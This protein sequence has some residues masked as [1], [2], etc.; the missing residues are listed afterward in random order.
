M[1]STPSKYSRFGALLA[2]T[3]L[4][5]TVT[6]A[7]AEN[8]KFTQTWNES[9]M[10]KKLGELPYIFYQFSTEAPDSLKEVPADVTDPLFVSFLSG[11]DKPRLPHPIVVEV[12]DK[13]PTRLFVDANADGEFSKDE[14]LDWEPKELTTRNGEK[15]TRYFRSVRMK[16]NND[17]KMGV[18]N[19]RYMRL[20]ETPFSKEEPLLACICDYG[21]T[22]EVTMGDRTI[23]IALFDVSASADFSSMA[24]GKAPLVWFDGNTNG[25]YNPGETFSAYKTFRAQRTI[26]AITNATPDG[27]FELVAVPSAATVAKAKEIA[28]DKVDI[29]AGQKA[30]AFTAKLI[31]GKPLN[32]PGDYK[33]KVVLIDFWATWCA[34]CLAEVPNVVANYEKYHAQGFE[35]LG[36]SLDRQDS[37][38]AV[39]KVT[40]AKNMTWPQ[41]YDGDFWDTAVVRLYGITGIPQMVLVDGDTGVIL[42]SGKDIRG[43]GL[44]EAIE[45]ALAARKKK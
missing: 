14:I 42:A 34:P 31:D 39:T 29:S 5:L 3:A 8:I 44:G 2:V 45:D 15:L 6:S 24:R 7:R 41:I 25:V 11:A 10:L 28:A 27:A 40:K 22:G 9:G 32:F 38:K 19:F 13:V 43:E 35:V 30:P 12:K 36:I 17:G 33:G 16:L 21:V 1:K 23:P 18:I 4:V 37:S 20:G 26:W